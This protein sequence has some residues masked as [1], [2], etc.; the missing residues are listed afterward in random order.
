MLRHV[1]GSTLRFLHCSISTS[2]LDTRLSRFAS[3]IR[4][5]QMTYC[6]TAIGEQQV[7]TLDSSRRAESRT[8][9]SPASYK[10]AEEIHERFRTNHN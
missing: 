3:K 1:P 10:A 9:N 6:I 8:Y 7:R 5:L 2:E 4:Y